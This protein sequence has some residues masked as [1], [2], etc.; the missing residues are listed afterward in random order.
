MV[1]QS[2]SQSDSRGGCGSNRGRAQCPQY[3]YDQCYQLHGRP[4][5]TGHFAQFFDHSVS[6]NSIS[7]SSSTPQG[8]ILT[9]DEY[10]EYLRLT[11]ATKSRFIAY[12]VR[13]GNVSTC[14]THSSAP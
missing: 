13:T 6:S 1:F 14:L 9:P 5:S 2:H 12:V 8:I 11:Q 3:T 4:P 10:E 7:G